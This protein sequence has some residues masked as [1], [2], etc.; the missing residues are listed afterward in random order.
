MATTKSRTAAKRSS[1]SRSVR[2]IKKKQGVTKKQA[3]IMI[4]AVALIGGFFVYKSFAA[5]HDYVYM[6]VENAN[7]SGTVQRSSSDGASKLTYGL[8]WPQRLF[9]GDLLSRDKTRILATYGGKTNLYNSATGALV[10]QA[11][12]SVADLIT[13]S[14]IRNGRVAS[15]MPGDKTVLVNSPDYKFKV[16]NLSTGVITTFPVPSGYR[17]FEQQNISR[18]GKKVVYVACSAADNQEVVI[19]AN[20]DGSGAK[21]V[22]KASTSG[23]DLGHPQWSNDGKKISY[24][25]SNETSSQN[26]ITVKL[27]VINA[28]GSGDKLLSNVVSNHTAV[29]SGDRDYDDVRQYTETSGPAT[30]HDQWSTGSSS[31]IFKKVAAGHIENLFTIDINTGKV[32][33]VTSNTSPNTV[34]GYYGV[35]AGNRIVY[36]Y[37]SAGTAGSVYD[38]QTSVVSVKFDGTA[39]RMLYTGTTPITSLLWW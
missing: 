1:A 17:S 30:W 23:G 12:K 4:A 35:T 20:I 32:S 26:N 39:R 38:K 28:D 10:G 19:S 33:P 7:G 16:A 3:S 36:S 15:F 27:K 6:G 13:D 29:G 24:Y 18:D 2:V 31:I 9:D 5:T 8:E 34:I 25:E 11:P 22:R 14:V 37:G 21:V